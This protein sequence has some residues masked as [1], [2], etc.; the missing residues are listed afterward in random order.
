MDIATFRLTGVNSFGQYIYGVYLG[1]NGE[2][3]PEVRSIPD[4]GL[5]IRQK[6]CLFSFAPNCCS[7]RYCPCLRVTSSRYL[8]ST[9][10]NTFWR[11]ISV[12]SSSLQ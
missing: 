2:I 4:L 3:P 1:F 7:P 11:R 5:L 6:P 12:H 9:S 8:G 10:Q